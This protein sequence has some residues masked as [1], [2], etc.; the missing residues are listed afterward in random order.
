[1]PD[2]N[3]NEKVV[4]I[5]GATGRLGQRVVARFAQ[6]GATIAA[7]VRD[8]ASF[9]LPEGVAGRAFSADVTDEADV[10]NA[11]QQIKATLGPVD[12]LIHTVGTWDGRPFLE[13]TFADWQRIIDL[14]LTSAFLCFREA[15]RQMDGRGGLLTGFASGQGADQGRARQSGYSAAKSGVIRLVEA[16][17]EEY[18]GTGVTAHAIAPS[19]ILFD[20]NS[21]AKG[22]P[23]EDLVDLVLYLCTSAGASLNGATLRAY[24]TAR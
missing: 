19:S 24:G 22:V 20:E 16:I 9:T 10:A 4:V 2:K 3:L 6:H 13:T 17:A 1:M 12:V 5:T 7:L 23:V 14:N 21:D 15:A 11:F 18:N 8:A